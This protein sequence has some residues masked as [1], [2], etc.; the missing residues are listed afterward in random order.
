VYGLSFLR[1]TPDEPAQLGIKALTAKILCQG[2]NEALSP[3]DAEFAKLFRGME[4]LMVSETNGDPVGANS[5][6]Q[7]DS[8]ERWMFKTLINGL[9]SGNFPVPFVNTFAGQ[10][11]SDEALEIIYRNAPFPKGRGVYLSQDHSRVDHHVFRLEVVGRPTGV[12]G[13]RAWVMGSLFLLVLTD[14]TDAFPELA[15]AT[16]R[17]R[18]I[19]TAK[20]RNG[21]VLSWAGEF[22]DA[23]LEL[24]LSDGPV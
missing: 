2:H 13:L 8:I 1:A 14:E 5:Y 21:I 3:F 12:V 17:P 20:T 16:Y 19:V 7:G 4:R 9:F 10:P 23:E 6:G 11:P 22:T 24:R 18:K 15:T